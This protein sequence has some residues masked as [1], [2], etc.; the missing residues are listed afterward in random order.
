MKNN[1]F[2]IILPVISMT[3][4]SVMLILYSEKILL[5]AIV[6][7]QIPDTILIP[8]YLFLYMKRMRL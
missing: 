1:F 7:Y 6:L 2:K 5:T 4:I 8:L 3:V